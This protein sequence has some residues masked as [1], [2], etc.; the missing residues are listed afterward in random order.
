MPPSSCA[1]P[2]QCAAAL[3]AAGEALRVHMPVLR[4]A[5]ARGFDGGQS[6]DV[7]FGGL[8]TVGPILG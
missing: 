5:K 7:F 8:E 6:R 3:C 2:G 1:R 4:A